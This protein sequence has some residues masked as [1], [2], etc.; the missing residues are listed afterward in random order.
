M[1]A[2]AAG[3]I[4]VAAAAAAG[5]G[6]A[7]NGSGSNNSGCQ[8]KK[9][10]RVERAR[11]CRTYFNRQQRRGRKLDKPILPVNTARRLQKYAIKTYKNALL[12]SKFCAR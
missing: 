8:R 3:I 7:G 2:G 10:K 11:I 5:I 9:G 12:I 4:A 1:A 6:G